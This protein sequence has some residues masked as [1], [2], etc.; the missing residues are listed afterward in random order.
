MALSTGL[1]ALLSLLSLV[2]TVI[3]GSHRFI[4]AVMAVAIMVLSAAKSKGRNR[5]ETDFVGA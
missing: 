3:S 2:I 1:F 4:S 5:V